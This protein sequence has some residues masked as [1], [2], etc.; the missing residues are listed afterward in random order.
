MI[1]FFRR[2]NERAILA[3]AALASVPEQVKRTLSM[4]GKMADDLLRGLDF[5]LVVEPVEVRPL[6][7]EL[8]HALP[9]ALGVV[10]KDEGPP[11]RI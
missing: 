8:Q 2:R 9:H 3:A 7:D 1:F 6:A 5:H 10:P 4:A 11:A